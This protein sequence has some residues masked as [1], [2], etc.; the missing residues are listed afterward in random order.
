G[1]VDCID[2]KVMT[3]SEGK[4][5]TLAGEPVIVTVDATPGAR[6]FLFLFSDQDAKALALTTAIMPCPRVIRDVDGAQVQLL[7]ITKGGNLSMVECSG[8]KPHEKLS[9]RAKMGIYPMSPPVIDLTTDNDG[10][11]ALVLRPDADIP[12]Q[13]NVRVLVK[14]ATK[15]LKLDF[16]W[17]NED[18]TS[19]EKRET[20]RA[21][22]KIQQSI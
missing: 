10:C 4:L 3:D 18:E 2:V 14:R 16:M 11:A 6:T 19:Q 13:G 22:R 1:Y 17:S 8:F 7:K 21:T 12:Y 5:R 20:N 9:L 15:E